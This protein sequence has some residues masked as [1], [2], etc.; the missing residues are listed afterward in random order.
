MEMSIGLSS[1]LALSLAKPDQGCQSTGFSACCL[2]YG[3]ISLFRR[4]MVSFL[5]QSLFLSVL[6][7]ENLLFAV[8]NDTVKLLKNPPPGFSGGGRGG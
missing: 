7:V 1:A 4:F 2:R 8:S 5:F 6:P 3:L